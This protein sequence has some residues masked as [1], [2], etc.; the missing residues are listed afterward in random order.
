MYLI[1][2]V[3]YEITEMLISTDE[4]SIV[5][6]WAPGHEG[7]KLSPPF[8]LHP[9]ASTSH[10][11]IR[12]KRGAESKIMEG[13]H[14]MERKLGEDAS[15]KG[16][17]SDRRHPNPLEKQTGERDLMRNVKEKREEEDLVK[18]LELKK[19]GG[20]VIDEEAERREN[21]RRYKYIYIYIYIYG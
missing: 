7:V 16:D 8:L 9:E 4:I 18:E 1:S 19:G 2:I 3:E 17:K 11:A 14:F 13:K 12:R 21:D 6:A 5:A 15:L 10:R 20:R